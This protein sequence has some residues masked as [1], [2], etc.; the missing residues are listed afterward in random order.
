[1]KGPYGFLAGEGGGLHVVNLSDLSDPIRVGG[2]SKV[3]A[4]SVQVQGRFAY[5]AAS[6]QGFLIYD[7]INPANPVLTDHPW[8][9]AVKTGCIAA[10][11]ASASGSLPLVYQWFHNQTP[12]AGATNPVLILTNVTDL[13]AGSYLVQASNSLGMTSSGKALL[14][15]YHPVT[16]RDQPQSRTNL[17][18]TAVSF[19]ATAEGT[20]P[21]QYQWKKDGKNLPTA[22]NNILTLDPVR[23]ED[24]GQYRVVVNNI[25]GSVMSD[26]A[27]LTVL[28]PPIITKQPQSVERIQGSTAVFDVSATGT[29]PL[30]FQWLKNGTPIP[31]TSLDTLEIVKVQPADGA[32]YSVRVSNEYGSVTSSSATLSLRDSPPVLGSQS[33]NQSVAIGGTARFEVTPMGTPPFSY[34]WDKNGVPLLGETN[35]VLEIGNV[36]LSHEAEYRV[37]ISNA[38]GAV[39]SSPA[40][41]SILVQLVQD[42]SWRSVLPA[43]GAYS[44][45]KSSDRLYV[46]LGPSGGLGVVETTPVGR[47]N[48]LGGLAVSIATNRVCV[49][50]HYAYIA[51]RASGLMLIDVENPAKPR[52]ASSIDTPGTAMDVFILGTNAYVADG[53]AGLQII[54]ISDPLR[55]VPRGRMDT[56]GLA[57]AVQVAGAYAY[58]ADGLSGLVIID[59]QDPW[60][61]V[62][63]GGIDTPGTAYDLAVADH[64]VYLADGS[65]GLQIIDVQEPTVPRIISNDRPGGI[66]GIAYR[67]QIDP[68][69][70]IWIARGTQGIRVLNVRNPSNPISLGEFGIAGGAFDVWIEDGFVYVAAGTSGLQVWDARS[71]IP[72]VSVALLDT[73]TKVTVEDVRVLGDYAFLSVGKAGINILD[74]RNPAHPLSLASYRTRGEVTR[75]TMGNSLLITAEGTNE[76]EL[77]DIRDPLHPDLLGMIN[78]PGDAQD[79]QGIGRFLYVADAR[80]G[81][82]IIDISD[83]KNPVIAGNLKLGTSS[84]A[85]TIWVSGQ[86]AFVGGG[87]EKEV[88]T[89]PGLTEVRTALFMVDIGNPRKPRLIDSLIE[90]TDVYQIRDLQLLGERIFLSHYSGIT[91]MDFIGKWPPLR[92][93]GYRPVNDNM[94]SNLLFVSGKYA[95]LA[96]A[97]A[98]VHVLRISPSGRLTHTGQFNTSGQAKA[99]QADGSRLYVAGSTAGIQIIDIQ[100]SAKP[101]LLG[102][103]D[104]QDALDIDVNGDL[105]FVADG[106]AGLII[107]DAHKP[108]QL[109]VVGQ[110]AFPYETR[111][112]F[113]QTNITFA[114]AQSIQVVGPYA[115][116]V[117]GIGINVVDISNPTRPVLIE[118]YGGT[119]STSRRM[120]DVTVVGSKAYVASGANGL[121][122]LD[123]IPAPEGPPVFIT[124]PAGRSAALN[125]TITLFAEAQGTTPLHYQWFF[126]PLPMPGETNAQITL[127]NLQPS[128][129][130]SYFLQVSNSMGSIVSDPAELRI[131]LGIPGTVDA[132]LNS[133][134]VGS[135]YA[136][137]AQDDGRMMIGG[138]FTRV[139]LT[140]RN[141][142]ARLHPNGSLDLTFGAIGNAPLPLAAQEVRALAIQP[143]GKILVGGDFVRFNNV[144]C[145]RLVRIHPDGSLDPSFQLGTGADNRIRQIR[146]Q[147]D[148]KILTSGW[149]TRFNDVS[150]PGIARLHP[151]GR[152]DTAFAPTISGSG[153]DTVAIQ[154]DGRFVIAG[155][156]TMANGQPRSSIARFN[157]NGSLDST[158]ARSS[159]ATLGWI[160]HIHLDPLGRALVGG[161]FATID[162]LSQ[163]RIARLQTDGRADLSWRIPGGAD[164]TVWTIAVDD[165]EGV[166]IGGDFHRVGGTTRHGLARLQSDGSVD[167]QFAAHSGANASVAAMEISQ[168]GSIWI[169]GDFTT[170]EGVSSRGVARIFG[171]Q[172]VPL[173]P[174]V[175]VQFSDQT[176][177]TG[178]RVRFDVKVRGM[179]PLTYQWLLDGKA[180]EGATGATLILTKAQPSQNGIYSLMVSNACGAVTSPVASLTVTSPPARVWQLDDSWAPAL[181]ADGWVDSTLAQPDGKI[182]IAGS[183]THLNNTLRL[184]VA[185]LLSDGKIDPQFDTRQGPDAPVRALAMQSDGKILVGGYFTRLNSQVRRSVARLNAHGTLDESFDPGLSTDVGVETVAAAPDGMIWVGGFFHTFSQARRPGIARLHPDGTLDAN[186]E[187]ALSSGSSFTQVQSLSDGRVFA[188]GYYAASSQFFTNGLLGIAPNGDL[189]LHIPTTGVPSAFQAMD[190]GSLL[191]AGTTIKRFYPSGISDPLFHEAT[192]S[193]SIHAISRQSNGS[194]LVAGDF[195][196]VDSQWCPGLARLLPDGTLDP[197]FAPGADWPTNGMVWARSVLSLQDHSI[198]VAGQFSADLTLGQP[199]LA[200]LDSSGKLDQAFG[201]VC[202]RSGT[203]RAF[204]LDSEQRLLVGGSFHRVNDLNRQAMIRF[205]SEGTFDSEYLMNG[206]LRGDTYALAVLPNGKVMAGG[207]FA[208][209]GPLSGTPRGLALLHTNGMSFEPTVNLIPT[210]TPPVLSLTQPDDN[211]LLI[212]GSFRY[213]AVENVLRLTLAPAIMSDT[214]FNSRLA[215]GGYVHVVT[216]LMDGTLLIGGSFK[217]LA[218]EKWQG[219]IRVNGN[220]LRDTHFVPPLSS[221]AIVRTISLQ[222]DGGILIGGI[223]TT[224]SDPPRTNLAR[225]LPDGQL[226]LTF[227]PGGGTDGPV[228]AMVVQSDGGIMVGGE[229]TRI[230]G[231]WS[232][233]LSRLLLDGTTD[234]HLAL[235]T[236]AYGH[237]LALLPLANENLLV[238]G[239]FTAI[240]GRPRNGLARLHPKAMQ[241][242]LRLLNPQYDQA[243]FRVS[244]ETQTGLFYILEY[245]DSLA[246]GPW[247]SLPPVAGTGSSV[248]LM[249]PTPSMTER[250]YRVRVSH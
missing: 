207:Y 14:T 65:Y 158:Y 157:A 85:N 178:D 41:L 19:T 57:T 194:I 179:T 81:L 31:E 131:M 222:P 176:A 10:F 11:E 154:P 121:T 219:L 67:V 92:V 111:D 212:G 166:L 188:M 193:G 44:L 74:I 143:D 84:L 221:T 37:A 142:I 7:V 75:I 36:Q 45:W 125:T 83:P 59:V 162:G 39:V 22:T 236:G 2:D 99:V 87:I 46:T 89:R 88:E 200:R 90:I 71:K 12:M 28:S 91:A 93:G 213:S 52:V 124:Q 209:A 35:A 184:R 189:D 29:L 248:V 108:D 177:A 8:D 79:V 231:R 68:E 33:T 76:I 38:L 9:Q 218:P 232:P 203:V 145:G 62:R 196:T 240:D 216:P 34:Q 156:F 27:T 227:D 241:A 78:T 161:M 191:V 151:D 130:G 187:P 58:V 245:C 164:N 51:N 186:F 47:L 243:S 192:C 165:A 146:L 225:L 105:I 117:D 5:V 168:D 181:W 199:G 95:F 238:G 13:Q 224:L 138:S 249:D 112:L 32:D 133:N 153:V 239:N 175:S 26:N 180:I 114:S 82:Q 148:G 126:G 226:D 220:G 136:L 100:E 134:V 246:S 30:A 77:I 127:F 234:A 86:F 4:I 40:T 49:A 228:N 113:G 140:L 149:F 204:A 214:T 107:V 98:G 1:M 206:G 17:T 54:D 182:V 135:V 242:P 119:Y 55:P 20:G 56:A 42:G 170:V 208:Q 223:F 96:D 102:E 106:S 123:G 198:L 3:Y 24:R 185:R 159:S 150:R 190:D 23:W 230:A 103:L 118:F 172:A 215:T 43:G 69:N 15:V 94:P 18:G 48:P 129:A 50:G 171:L 80:A 202:Q 104:T 163:S 160:N 237:V 229:F 139:G 64:Y 247:F 217:T 155:S 147:P 16:I 115:Y 60:H 152:L 53:S 183:F 70:R 72:A 137:A 210:G 73:T 21:F 167:A 205:G 197:A 116:V 61:P 97:A 195:K 25:F 169:G 211:H 174:T 132:A 141:R 250:F 120:S 101:A 128:H 144:A 6:W 235:G 122:I 173:P 110:M 201:P 66:A 233:G 109:T 63:I 244:L